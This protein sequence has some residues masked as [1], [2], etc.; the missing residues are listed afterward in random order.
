MN[1]IRSSRIIFGNRQQDLIFCD[2]FMKQFSIELEYLESPRTR[3]GQESPDI[4]RYKLPQFELG[5]QFT[6]I[7][8]SWI[9]IIH[10]I[11]KIQI[12]AENGK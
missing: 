1:Q 8:L 12:I 6:T 2:S 7:Y 5:M 9:S 4:L 10:S 3:K 11:S